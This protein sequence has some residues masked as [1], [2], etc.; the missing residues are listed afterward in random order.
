MAKLTPSG[1]LAAD[2]AIE[3]K[4][5]WSCK[6]TI[7]V[8]KWRIGHMNMGKLNH[9]DEM[10]QPQIDMLGISKLR[11]TGIWHIQSED[12]T[13]YY[14]EP[15]QKEGMFLTFIVWKGIAETVL[16]TMQKMTK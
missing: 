3:K 9:K 1:C 5:I 11:C 4:K 12:H 8:Q 6:D 15:I 16:D 7:T 10:K 14:S 13:A 2:V